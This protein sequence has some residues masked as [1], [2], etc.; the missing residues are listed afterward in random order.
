MS[1]FSC[2]WTLEFLGLG[3]WTPGL[4]PASLHPPPTGFSGLHSQTGRDTIG[5]SYFQVF[6]L[7]LNNTTRS[8]GSPACRQLTVG[9]LSIHNHISHFLFYIYLLLV[10]FL[11]KNLT[12]IYGLQHIQPNVLHLV[13]AALWLMGARHFCLHGLFLPLKNW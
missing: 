10:L 13:R 2:P 1:I 4:K 5:S 9:L 12:N 7:R 3:P 8:P 11:W 6:G